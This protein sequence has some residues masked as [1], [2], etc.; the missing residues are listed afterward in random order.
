MDLQKVGKA[1]TYRRPYHPSRT[2][3]F[4]ILFLI[5]I[6]VMRMPTLTPG[7]GTV[8]VRTKETVRLLPLI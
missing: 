7:V 3:L 5:V 4:G 6:I 1:P 2:S 8:D